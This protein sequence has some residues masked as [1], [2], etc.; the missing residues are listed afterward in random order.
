MKDCFSKLTVKSTIRK[1]LLEFCKFDDNWI[2]PKVGTF[3]QKR[4][5]QSL[6]FSDPFLK[7]VCENSIS[8]Y[9]FNQCVNIFMIMPWTHYMLHTD[10]SRSASINL[11]IN[12]H[13]DSIS[14]FQVTEPYNKLHVGIK[15]LSYEQDAYYLFNSKIRHAV[16]NRNSARYLLSITLRD[17]YP[18]MLEYLKNQNFL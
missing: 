4:P 5:S 17:D 3:L 6:I 13:C 15:E 7:H 1:D 14:Y 8:E 12:D 9:G 16:T 18:T 11:L 10:S 2:D